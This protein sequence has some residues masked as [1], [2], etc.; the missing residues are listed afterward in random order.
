MFAFV[1]PVRFAGGPLIM[2]GF[3]PAGWN[4]INRQ[5]TDPTTAFSPA[6]GPEPQLA[7]LARALNGLAVECHE[8][9]GSG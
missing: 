9:R 2:T 3:V 6:L 7:V 8:T 4:T 5:T 1:S